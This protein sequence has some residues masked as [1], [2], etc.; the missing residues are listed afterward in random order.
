MPLHTAEFRLLRATELFLADVFGAHSDDAELILK[1]VQEEPWVR[2][3]SPHGTVTPIPAY[4]TPI[5]AYGTPIPA[6]GTP[7]PALGTRNSC[8]TLRTRGTD[9]SQGTG[10]TY[11][12]RPTTCGVCGVA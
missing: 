6:Y 5:P 2:S 12:C 9:K 11:E 4:G 7:I 10:V 3:A 8:L 1:M